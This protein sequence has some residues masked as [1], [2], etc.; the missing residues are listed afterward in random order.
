MTDTVSQSATYESGTTA[1]VRHHRFMRRFGP[2]WI[3]VTGVLV[4]V[5][6]LHWLIHE[7]ASPFGDEPAHLEMAYGIGR[8]WAS[9]D[10]LWQSFI[11]AYEGGNGRYPPL[12]YATMLPVMHMAANPLIAARLVSA[13]VT[14]AAVL[15]F[16]AAAVRATGRT[17]N[18]FICA[19]ALISSPLV[20]QAERY[21]LLEGYLLFWMALLVYA[22]VAFVQTGRLGWWLWASVIVGLGLL[23]K[24]NFLMYTGVLLGMVGVHELVRWRTGR[25]TL[26][27]VIARFAAAAIIVAVI[28]GPWYIQNA[29]RPGNAGSGLKGLIEVGHLEVARTPRRVVEMMGAVVERVFPSIQSWVMLIIGVCW[30]GWLIRR[31]PAFSSADWLVLSGIGTAVVLGVMLSLIGLGR[32]VR[33][34]L[35]YV[36]LV[37]V[38]V[39]MLDT[40]AWSPVRSRRTG[41]DSPPRRRPAAV[42]A[43][44]WTLAAL[45]LV[46]PVVLLCA[47]NRIIHFD[48]VPQWSR[49]TLAEFF[50]S[51]DPRPT[52]NVE[53]AH[54]IDRTFPTRDEG[55]PV[56]VAFMV[57]DHRGFHSQTVGWELGRLART[58][59]EI[60]RVGFFDRPVDID[61]FLTADLIVTAEFEQMTNDHEAMRYQPLEDRLPE[62]IGSSFVVERSLQTRHF[63]A[64]LLRPSQWTIDCDTVDRMLTAARMQDPRPEVGPYY[65]LLALVWACRLECSFPGDPAAT[66]AAAASLRA[67][68][69]SQTRDAVGAV[70]RRLKECRRARP[71]SK[72]IE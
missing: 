37:L 65:D 10:G 66:E 39:V 27:A 55:D 57:H 40:I 21:V 52:G 1:P 61:Q 63:E 28:A 41:V 68:S 20:I 34:H 64:T 51:P 50:G 19:L 54:Y 31:R 60:D 17:R 62:L 49:T 11:R 23:T 45:L 5:V 36:L 15:I 33:W 7:S 22:F 59:V 53:L 72:G 44:G 2:A 14:S 70:Q 71:G 18:G 43:C 24:F 3:W 67:A 25:T 29:T 13:V 42:R 47:T 38:V 26:P 32:E 56:R 48:R 6:Q 4:A 16:S 35:Q 69:P 46:G 8:A 12:A 9:G 30:A 58:D